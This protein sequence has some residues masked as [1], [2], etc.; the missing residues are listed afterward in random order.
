MTK[1]NPS[2]YYTLLE[3]NS[4]YVVVNKRPGITIQRE[5]A[6]AKGERIS[7]LHP[8]RAGLLQ[9]VAQDLGLEKL[10]P[11]HR[12]DKMTSGL[13]I[14]AVTRECNQRL[15]ALFADRQVDKYYLAISD[16]KPKKKQGTIIGDMEKSRD[17]GWILQKC[18]FNPAITQFFSRSIAP[19]RRLYILKPYTGKTHQ[20]RVA[21]KSIAAPITGDPQYAQTKSDRGYLHSMILGFDWKGESKRYQAL[22]ETGDWF[23]DDAFLEG[24]KEFSEPWL[25][26]WP[27]VN[28]FNRPQV[29]PIDAPEVKIDYD[30]SQTTDKAVGEKPKR[31]A[32]K[33]WGSFT[34]RADVKKVEPNI[35]ASRK[36]T[37]VTEQKKSEDNQVAELAAA[38]IEAR[39]DAEP[40]KK[41]LESNQAVDVNAEDDHAEAVK[42]T[43]EGAPQT[44][45]PE[46]S[47]E[48]NKGTK[49]SWGW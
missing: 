41:R 16:K 17:G 26:A 42:V 32:A 13:V 34:E 38:V 43:G 21:L 8:L 47:K 15:S 33:A 27:E 48:K 14:M 45:S 4:D 23:T 40:I 9:L 44:A 31:V 1:Y 37:S 18:K 12:L 36:A 2:N 35:E 30:N 49:K 6:L 46:S 22:P 29:R 28:T 20:I 19:H 5:G 39:Q 11:V 7:E 3:H 24:F 10:Y 25:L